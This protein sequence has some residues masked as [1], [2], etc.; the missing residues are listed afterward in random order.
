MQAQALEG[1]LDK[2]GC[3][4]DAVVLIKVDF[5]YLFK[6]LTGRR[7]SSLTGKSLNVYFSSQTELE[8]C[9][10]AGANL[11]SGETT[12]KKSSAID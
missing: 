7:T 11:S 12:M 6:R 8:A 4:L 1:M 3:P 9:T 10:K 5:E 2:M